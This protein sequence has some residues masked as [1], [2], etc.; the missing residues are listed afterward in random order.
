MWSRLGAFLQQAVETRE[1][2]QDLLPSFIQHWK[3]V[4][5][6]YLET[7]DESCPARET[8]IPWRLRQL[9]DILVFEESNNGA[10]E[11][12]GDGGDAGTGSHAGPCMEYLLQ[13]KILET[14]CTL[15]KAEYPPGMRQQVLLFYSRLLTKVQRP[16][17]HYLSVHRPVQKLIALAEDPV[18]ATAQ[19]EE[20]QFLTAVCT[21]LEEDPSLLVHVL[22][23]ESVRKVQCSGGEGDGETKSTSHKPRHNL[24]K[25][26]LR[27][28]TCQKS[29][30]SVRAREALLRV[31]HSAQQEGPVHL[32]VQSKL[33]QYVTEH[34]CELHRC[35]PL[36]IHPCDITALQETDWR[37]N[38]DNQESDGME[39][40]EAAL[41]RFL[42]WVE[43]CDSLVQ[44]SHEIVA[45]DITK[46]IK[47]GYLQGILQPEL[48]E[49]SELSI[50]RSTAILTAVL[51]RFTATPLLR[52]F[53]TFLLSDEQ[54]PEKRSDRGSQL[55]AQLIQR[56]NHLSDEISLA[57]LRLFE[58][59]LQM[60]E[61]IVLY[62]LVTR[63]LETR[64]YLA[65][66][67]DESRGQESE[68]W[69]GAE[70]LEEDPYFTDGFPDTGIRLPRSDR[71]HRTEIVG[72]EQWVKSFLSLV[73]EEIKSSD[74]G[75]DGYLQDA[76]VQ[77][78]A[79]CQQVAQWGWPVS[80]KPLGTGHCQQEFY[81]GHFMEVLFDRLGG[82]LDQPYDVNLQVTSLLS[83]LALFPHPHLQEYLLNPFITLAPAARSLFS[84]LVRV[85]ADLAQRSLRVPDLQ[86]T[87]L[88]V[89]RQLQ[90]NS[91]N[92]QLNHV[93][94]CQGAV[95]L[96]EFCKELAAAAC[97]THNSVG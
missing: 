93:T 18:G 79:C 65:G 77:Y 29:R 63:N 89:R 55:R 35:I 12:R 42:C 94:L 69:D 66:G 70:E 6:Y 24:F 11:A 59:I 73:P 86:E 26:L 30:L 15:A 48:L 25:A 2:T 49:V 47:D 16:L 8:D 76:I 9:T 52:Q 92:E 54:G 20:L 1:T 38:I 22:E 37:K 56:C 75:Y 80:S 87:L 64:S 36:S 19:K 7:S 28:C 84:V 13:H 5:Q 90:A 96:E 3:G 50:L 60:P 41:R 61:E 46:S 27:L 95:V 97:V 74:T 68:T 85:V 21:K 23:E 34:L 91:A 67:L 51:Q 88:L 4:T 78:R 58:E 83:R 44:E 72:T 53:L 32:I 43:Y 10:E 82:I 57:S 39:N 40:S 62:S 45:M 33:S 71:E 17:L 14:L 81:E 31:L